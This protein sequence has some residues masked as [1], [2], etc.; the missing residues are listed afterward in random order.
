MEAGS[1]SG[2]G[3]GAGRGRARG[4]GRGR[5]RGRA[6]AQAPIGAWPGAGN[7][8]AGNQM[9]TA[10]QRMVDI[11]ERMA[12][13]QDQGRGNNNHN[14]NQKGEDKAL[15]R[16]QK[17]QP[18]K[19]QGGPN[20]DEAE[21]WLDRISDIFAALGYT[22]ERQIVF[23]VFQFEGAARAW[24]NV[25][26]AKWEREQTP[27]TW[28]NFT[29]EFNEK[30]LPPIVQEQ[31][32]AEFMRLCQG[33]QSVAEY[34]T[35]FTKLARFAPDLVNTEAKRIRRFVQGL[36]VEIQD[37]LATAQLDTF[38]QVLEKAQRSERAKSQVRAFRDKKRKQPEPNSGNKLSTQV[39][40]ETGG[41]Q[42][43]KVS[44][45]SDLLKPDFEPICGF[46]EST[47]H[48]EAN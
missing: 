22:E 9:A 32:E 7:Q 39:D 27:W 28:A 6:R 1:T 17:F 29:R 19:F 35:Q 24:W 23:A 10:F 18:P 15:E 14:N 20:P 33:A 30:F 21:G 46:C 48:K 13:Q 11:V 12:G 16:F 26:R 47:T 45:Q 41:P 2:Q 3:R 44:S 43:G 25:I 8:P 36:N 5:G 31:R 37:A 42:S 4:G 40:G 38:S 34:E